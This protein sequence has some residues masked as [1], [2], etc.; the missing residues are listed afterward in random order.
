MRC[1]RRRA[2]SAPRDARKD[3]ARTLAARTRILGASTP[4]GTK[5]G[6]LGAERVQPRGGGDRF[7]ESRPV[8]HEGEPVPEIPVA[9]ILRDRTS[10]GRLRRTTIALDQL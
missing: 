6:N 4:S 1:M 10:Q 7:P 9:P 3:P 5:L 8:A 2:E